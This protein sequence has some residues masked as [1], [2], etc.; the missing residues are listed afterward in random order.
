MTVAL[1]DDNRWWA[2]G[3][4]EARI[5]AIYDAI[6]QAHRAPAHIVSTACVS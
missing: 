4:G 2:R 5:E 1:T 3:F 6:G